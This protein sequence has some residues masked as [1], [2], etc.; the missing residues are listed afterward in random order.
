MADGKTIMVH[1]L[2]K[3]VNLKNYTIYRPSA[4]TQAYYRS[5]TDDKLSEVIEKSGWVIGM[6]KG[7]NKYGF[8]T[9]H[10][11]GIGDAPL[12]ENYLV[13]EGVRMRGG[14]RRRSQRRRRNQRK[15]RRLL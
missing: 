9:F 7:L 1:N 12:G 10:V 2:D 6:Y 3:L 4:Q 14:H 13:F 8:H 11:S 15:T 5:P